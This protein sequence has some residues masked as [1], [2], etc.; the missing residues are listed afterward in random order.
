M[1]K[2]T[3]HLS[4]KIH[5]LD[6]DYKREL[7]QTY[8]TGPEWRN[9][10]MSEELGEF[11]GRNQ[12]FYRFPFFKQI[13]VFWKVF[14]NSYAKAREHHTHTQ[15]I[16]SEYML[17]GLFIGIN[18]TLEWGAKGLISLFFWPFLRKENN[19]A[20]Q[21]QVA[22]TFKDYAQ[23]IHSVP[24]YNYSYFK[25]LKE[26]ASAFWYSNGKSFAD[27][28][29]FAI[30]AIDFTARGIVSAPVGYWYNQEENQ[31][32]A[33]TDIIVKK[34]SPESREIFEGKFKQ[35]LTSINQE[36]PDIKLIEDE[37]AYFRVSETKCLT[38][39][40][41]RLRVPRYEGFETAVRILHTQGFKIAEIAGQ[42]NIQV[43]CITDTQDLFESLSYQKIYSYKNGVNPQT[44][45]ALNVGTK[46]LS[47]AIQE[48]DTVGAKIKLIHAF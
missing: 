33:T 41:T 42:N 45:F 9:V 11:L 8:L 39:A 10:E 3:K 4:E 13:G 35:Q 19:T 24:F 44:F 34:S 29:T 17:M 7:Y 1:G 40:Y 47:N 30:V 2:F 31:A 12:S 20:F 46:T 25:K 5:S 32:A 16:F 21:T 6:K 26:L 38:Y 14:F 48:L 37:P 22:G 36:C 15:L 28:I 18:T 23:F 43:K 27:V